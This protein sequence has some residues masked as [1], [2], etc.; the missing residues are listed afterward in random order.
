MIYF[1]YS[2]FDG[3]FLH[4][5]P[6]QLGLPN[7]STQND[8]V[9]FDHT[10]AP[11]RVTF[12]VNV[13]LQHKPYGI[14]PF[15]APMVPNMTPLWNDFDAKHLFGASGSSASFTES[16]GH[17]SIDPLPMPTFP[18]F[19][20][21]MQ[22]PSQLAE[23]SASCTRS[24]EINDS[25]VGNAEGGNGSSNS[26]RDD[27]GGSSSSIG[28]AN[29]SR[30]NGE[31]WRLTFP[32]GRRGRRDAL[33][34]I[35]PSS[36]EAVKASLSVADDDAIIKCSDAKSSRSNNQSGRS[37]NTENTSSK[38]KVA[39]AI[40]FVEAARIGAVKLR[41]DARRPGASHDYDAE[42]NSVA[43]GSS[44]VCAWVE[45]LRS[46]EDSGDDEEDSN[47]EDSGDGELRKSQEDG[48]RNAAVDEQKPKRRRVEARFQTDTQ[49]CFG[50]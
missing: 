37:G 39:P 2:S 40:S 42:P 35:W 13:W 41:L 24:A 15:P 3:R 19:P 30:D 18:S 34:L 33:R 23:S 36:L 45:V 43:Y 11:M 44:G 12:L 50:F 31:A 7:S 28:S 49:A 48:N 25:G 29:K 20:H 22:P 32:L 9:D 21:P 10:A 26:V 6:R 17:R 46:D 38:T 5:A 14:Q 47:R 8:G 4:G 1:V 27:G 16:R